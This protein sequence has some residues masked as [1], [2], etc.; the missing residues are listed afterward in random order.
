M[1]FKQKV[2]AFLFADK[3]EDNN[4]H[5]MRWYNQMVHEMETAD[6]NS[7][8]SAPEIIGWLLR[9]PDKLLIEIKY[10]DN[11]RLP[12]EAVETYLFRMVAKRAIANLEFHNVIRIREKVA[13]E[14]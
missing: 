4:A 5:Q 6:V 10:S 7:R 11:E 13:Q 12:Y 2:A 1:S 3:I 14:V 8:T 9:Q